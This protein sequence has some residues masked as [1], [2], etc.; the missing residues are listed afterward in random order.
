MNKEKSNN[1]IW[2]A[3]YPKSGN[4]WLRFLIANY[5]FNNEK[6]FNFDVVRKV[7]KFP[8]KDHLTFVKESEILDNPYNIAKYWIK[9]QE[10][11]KTIG[12]NVTFLKTHTPLV[13]IDNNSFTN[14]DSSLAVLHIV[15]DPRDIAISYSKFLKESYDSIIDFMLKKELV[16]RIDRKNPLDLEIIGSWKFNYISWKDGLPLVPKLLIKYEDLL[17]NTNEE[18]HKILTF[19]SKILKF[20]IDK[21]QLEFA[22]EASQF[23]LLS[24]HEKRHGFEESSKKGGY[25]FREGSKSQWKDEL[26]KDQVDKIETNLNFEM[27]NLKYI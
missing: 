3:S 2:L 11:L 21:K 6:K 27:K 24:N 5:F 13:T 17:N 26:T 1:I 25:F 19:L 14:E 15:R 20:D 18:F 22:V 4:T 8:Q 16:Y 10:L 9:G 7:D 23:N 12:G